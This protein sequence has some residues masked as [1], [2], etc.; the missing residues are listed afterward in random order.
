LDVVD[1]VAEDAVAEG[2][3][4]LA[5]VVVEGSAVVVLAADPVGLDGLGLAA[6]AAS[7]DDG[8]AHNARR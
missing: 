1:F 7:P 8:H 6:S 2:L 5:A 4:G 3:A